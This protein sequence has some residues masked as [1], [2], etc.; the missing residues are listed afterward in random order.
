MRSQED[1]NKLQAAVNAKTDPV[2][3]ATYDQLRDYYKDNFRS[4][5]WIGAMAQAVSGSDKRSGKEYK[6]ARRSI[7]RHESGQYK[8]FKPVYVSGFQAAGMK[9]DPISRNPKGGMVSITVHG[10]QYDN[11]PS[12]KGRNINATFGGSEAYAFA[13][14]PSYE[15]IWNA[16][17]VHPEYFEEGSGEMEIVSVS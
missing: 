14:N 9:L 10:N 4:D 7:E 13:N 6:A 11:V 16:Y 1:M 2:Y 17:G 8:G 12:H 5:Q 3:L 15:A